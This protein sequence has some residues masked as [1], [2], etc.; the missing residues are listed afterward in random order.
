MNWGRKAICA[1]LFL[2]AANFVCAVEFAQ[3][4]DK[5]ETTLPSFVYGGEAFDASKWK[6]ESKPVSDSPKM[7]VRIESYT[8]PDGLL[9]VSQTITTYKKFKAVEWKTL[10]E[11][12]GTERTQIVEDFFPLSLRIKNEKHNLKSDGVN[13]RRYRGT[14]T[15]MT[16]F[17]PEPFYLERRNFAMELSME[18][19][20]GYSS[21]QW[22]PYFGLDF[23]AMNGLNAAIGWSGDWLAR[24]NLDGDFFRAKMGMKKTRFYLNPDEK[25]MQPSILVAERKNSDIASAQNDWRALILEHFTP[26]GADGKPFI[27]PIVTSAGGN[28]PEKYFLDAVEKIS[29]EKFGFE[30]FGID[31]GWFGGSNE[32]KDK[33]SFGDWLV[34]A[35]DWSE[36]S[37]IYPDGLRNISDAARKEGMLFSLWCEIERVMPDTPIARKHPEYVFTASKTSKFGLLNLGNPDARK[38][39]FNTLSRTIQKHRVDVWRI[40]SNFDNIAVVWKEIDAENPDREGVAEAKYVKGF[41]GLFD[42]IRRAF[43]NLQ[44]DNCAGGGRRL[45]YETV[46]RTFCVWRSDA[47]CFRD[48]EVAE[49]NQLQN[50]YLN[51]WLPSH[52]GG[53]GSPISDEY[54]YVSSFSSGMM[55]PIGAVKNCDKVDYLKKLIGL[56]K[57]MR[58]YIVRDFY[59]L[60]ANPENMRNW[61]AF[62][63]HA[64]DE[65]AGFFIAFRRKISPSQ[66]EYLRL[67]AIDSAAVY[68]LEDKS[69]NKREISGGD[70]K[71]FALELRPRDY[72][73]YFYKKIK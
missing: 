54:K 70:L 20:Q 3:I 38:W 18:T 22:M 48:D 36:N 53:N 5:S 66:K 71:D 32:P 72:A 47:Q 55:V 13:I 35:G 42:S 39:A 8:S 56:S 4:F 14:R 28:Y 7:A 6:R 26:R 33:G 23:D 15:S 60:L 34:K 10:L 57:R 51:M 16:D 61:C 59:Q 19:D 11:N 12:V 29:K 41:Y 24:F 45:D 46:S 2:T 49:S 40:D 62:Q 50:Y 31:A 30:L 63:A 1:A 25:L 68:E 43:P 27:T 52:S 44:I 21:G 37:T 65:S 58:T 69:G 67:S 17:C 73:V 64:P 9:K